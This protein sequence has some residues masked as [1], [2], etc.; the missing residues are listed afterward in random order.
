MGGLAWHHI[1]F[2][3]SAFNPSS[4]SLDISSQMPLNFSFIQSLPSP[5]AAKSLQSCP[6]LCDPIDGS[7]PGSS[8]PRQEHWSGLPFPFPMH[9]SEMWKW[10]CSVV[11]D[12]QRPHGLQPSRLLH[13][14]DVPGK[15]T[16]VGCHCFLHMRSNNLHFSPAGVHAKLLL[17]CLTI[18]N[19]IYS[20]SGS[21]FHWFF[22]QEY[23]SGL[24]WPLP[25]D[26][27]NPGIQT[28]S[29]K[30]PGVAGGFFL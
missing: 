21:S 2:S 22:R 29:L 26:L 11:S 20:P 16:G 10:S 7:P 28:T 25:G 17:L 3:K 24:P 30:T 19:I 14:W 27:P 13:P 5:A 1:S 8:V 9:E 15:S 18:C 23:W 12:P 6:T 4:N